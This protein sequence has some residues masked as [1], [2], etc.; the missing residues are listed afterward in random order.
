MHATTGADWGEGGGG[1]RQQRNGW[2]GRGHKRVGVGRGEGKKKGVRARAPMCPALSHT[3]L[4]RSR[5][6]T[7]LLPILLGQPDQAL[8]LLGVR[9]DGLAKLL[10]DCCVCRREKRRECERERG[11]GLGVGSR[12]PPFSLFF[13]SS[14]PPVRTLRVQRDGFPP[15]HVELLDAHG[16]AED[17]DQGRKGPARRLVAHAGGDPA[18]GGRGR[19]RR[20]GGGWCCA[21]GAAW[22][23]LCVRVCV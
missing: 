17:D 9:A 11:L 5:Q 7:E 8:H 18:G 20:R 19:A 3:S 12:P 21:G 14:Q 16:I 1:G 22:G 15:E 2:Q 10:D 23:L 6:E 4:S 13:R